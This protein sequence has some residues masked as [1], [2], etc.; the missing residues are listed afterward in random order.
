MD[1]PGEIEIRSATPEDVD[2]LVAFQMAMASETED[3]SLDPKALKHGVTAVFESSQRGFYLV[4]EVRGQ[5][6][7][8]LLITYEWSDWHN[9][10]RWW[11]QSV[12]VDRQWRRKGVY[13][14][15]YGR[16]QEMA[17]STGEVCAIRLYVERDNMIG[18]RTYET[19]GMDRAPYYIYELDSL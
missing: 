2:T 1:V 19:L 5:V 17:R 4:A 13:R 9:A 8:D 15:L 11:I 18:Q 3:K 14:A 16:V 6:V 7:G 12:F 10:N